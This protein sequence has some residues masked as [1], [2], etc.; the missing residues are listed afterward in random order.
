MRLPNAI[1]TLFG[2]PVSDAPPSWPGERWDILPIYEKAVQWAAHFSD[3]ENVREV[4]RNRGYWVTRF[5][6]RVGLGP[7]YAWCAAF[8]SELLFRAGWNRFRSA[9]VLQWRDWANR[10]GRVRVRPSRGMLAYWVK[11][12]GP[13]QRR[14]IEIVIS[15]AGEACPT[16]LHSSGKVPAGW[17]QT[18]GGNTGPGSGGSQ[19]DGDGVYRRIRKITDFTGFVQWW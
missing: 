11:G 13:S 14:H 8:V 12:S 3:R 4:G 9:A 2:G 6:A 7:G 16:S 10:E 15:V 19:E 5:L 18:I 17:V 1:Q